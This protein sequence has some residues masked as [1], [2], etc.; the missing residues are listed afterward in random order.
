MN[1][2]FC[3]SLAALCLL[4]CADLTAGEKTAFLAAFDPESDA[5]QLEFENQAE[6]G[7]FWKPYAVKDSIAERLEEN[8][9]RSA[10]SS[11]WV[12]EI[13]AWGAATDDYHCAVMLEMELRRF[14]VT[15]EVPGGSPVRTDLA[16]WDASEM[17]TGPKIHMDDR[18]H[19]WAVDHL[20]QMQKA[21]VAAKR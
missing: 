6:P 9:I 10:P 19:D 16:V 20:Q 1:S 7:C 4:A 2:R 3:I 13:V 21:M 11:L 17:L 15:A 18:I 12:L 14:S 8:G 5:I